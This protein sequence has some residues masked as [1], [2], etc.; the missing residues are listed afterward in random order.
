MRL[1]LRGSPRYLIYAAAGDLLFSV[2]TVPPATVRR[3]QRCLPVVSHIPDAASSGVHLVA[4]DIRE[5]Y[6][7]FLVETST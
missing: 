3:I 2:G 4:A 5:N 1:A 6:Y 7:R